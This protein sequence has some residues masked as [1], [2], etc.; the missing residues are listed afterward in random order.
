MKDDKSLNSTSPNKDEENPE[1]LIT[2]ARKAFAENGEAIANSTNSTGRYTQPAIY[3]ENSILH[4]YMV[5]TR[6]RQ[7]SADCHILASILPVFSRIL[8]RRIYFNWGDEKHFPN[9]FTIIVGHAGDRKSSAINQAKRIGQQLLDPDAFLPTSFSPEAMFEEYS[10]N[11]DKLWIVG[12]ANITLTDWKKMSHGERVATRFLD[13]YDC[14][15]LSESFMRNVGDSDNKSPSRSIPETFTSILFG[16]TFNVALFQGQQIQEG[17]AR[18]FLYYVA[19]DTDRIIIIPPA[20]NTIELFNLVRKL[21]PLKDPNI[22]GPIEF[23]DDANTIW[24]TYQINNRKEKKE[25]DPLNSAE[26]HRLNSSPMQVLH[27]AIIFE[28]CIWAKSNKPWRGKISGQALKIAIE[29]V[30]ACLEAASYM[31]SINNRQTV[32]EDSNNF[33]GRVLNEFDNQ[34][35]NGFIILTRTEITKKYCHHSNRVGLWKPEYI[36]K[37]LIPYLQRNNQ[38]ALI[39]K[40][41]KKETYAFLCE[42]Q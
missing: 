26:L 14:K 24:E 22:N 18:R 10:I 16:A 8:G 32:I 33:L 13:L 23:D 34:K 12:D 19:E 38:A 17:L 11:P 42:E 7:E 37:S 3:P 20:T 27:I 4:D 1:E 9:L 35:K 36:Y 15:D 28:T 40:E 29:H 2:L 6:K 21:E 39:K 30:D 31:E 5:Y 41:G 25:I